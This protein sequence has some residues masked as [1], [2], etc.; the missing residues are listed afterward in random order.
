MRIAL[1]AA[2]GASKLGIFVS[3]LVVLVL[4]L[5]LAVPAPA[6]TR[7][8]GVNLAD[9]APKSAPVN[10]NVPAVAPKTAEAI[11]A[12]QPL[13]A[14]T[15]P[16]KPFVLTSGADDRSRALTCLT[17]AIYYEAGFE[18]TKGQEAVAQVVL[19]R[20]R[21]PIFPHTVCGVVFQGSELKTGCQFSFTC[22]GS[23][24]R[25]PQ[26]A[27][28]ARARKVAEQALN[29]FVLKDVG[30]ATH[31]HTD[32]VV[33]WWQST[34]TKVARIGAHIFYRWPGALGMPG[35]LTM[36][37]AGNERTPPKPG[38]APSSGAVTAPDVT[39]MADG[40]VHASLTLA[41]VTPEPQTPRERLLAL[42]RQG[43]LGAGFDPAKIQPAS[44]PPKAA[45]VSAETTGTPVSGHVAGE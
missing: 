20:M 29:G 9:H 39:R 44:T 3:G 16:A 17:Q 36:R 35:A 34:V 25:A 38:A 43:A 45:P 21:H 41:A 18:P 40:R 1:P 22:D 15:G 42:S 23:L 33:P 11:N 4:A 28:W 2:P 6:V 31:Y 10:L 37:Y 8:G 19:N 32:W 27:A 14:P 30:S 12:A 24:A 13:A 5:R 26:P 7:A